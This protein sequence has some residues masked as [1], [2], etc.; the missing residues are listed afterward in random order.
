MKR[1][2]RDMEGSVIVVTGGASGVGRA[3]CA[4]IIA[5]GG[6][7]I[8][9]DLDVTKGKEVEAELGKG[10]TFLPLDVT[11]ENQ[12]Q[13]LFATVSSQRGR[14]NGLVNCAG[15]DVRRDNVD[16]LEIPQWQR[17][18][19]VNL[20]GVFLG[21]KYVLRSMRELS[22]GGAIVN[23]S[24][25]L[26]IV[27]DGNAL[28]YSTSKGGV[29]LLTKSVALYAARERLGVRCNSVHPGYVATPM[30]E[31]WLSD[32]SNQSG[33]NIGKISTDLASAH[34]IGRLADPSEI[35]S[36]VSFLLS[37]AAA[38]I[39]GAEYVVDGGYIAA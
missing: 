29:R 18:M 8:A 35:A 37:P 32:V 12:W 15:I 31:R 27:A 7:A 38:Y 34:P 3:C 4:D 23:I 11:Q 22:C 36:V 21:C 20:E 13:Q 19:A 10:C 33:E 26:A 24:S 1:L 30:T 6:H 17:L 14:L 16:D 25:I 39:T 9:A 28:A 2:T 5:Q